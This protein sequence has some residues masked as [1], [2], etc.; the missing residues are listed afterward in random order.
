MF[1]LFSHCSFKSIGCSFLDGSQL[2]GAAV[3]P[4]CELG[5]ARCWLGA[6]GAEGTAGPGKPW[7]RGRGRGWVARVR[8]VIC[9]VSFL[10]SPF[11][12]P[13]RFSTVTTFSFIGNS[14]SWCC[15]GF[16]ERFPSS[17][18][19]GKPLPLWPGAP[20]T[21]ASDGGGARG[22]RPRPRARAPGLEAEAGVRL[23]PTREGGP[24]RR[25]GAG[26]RSLP[27]LVFRFAGAC[28]R[29]LEQGRLVLSLVIV[30]RCRFSV[31][32]CLSSS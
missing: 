26:L 9:F 32:L 4:V 25:A 5:W 17:P 30:R 22:R 18:W 6:G 21:E 23:H 29:R 7:G 3:L 24:A 13:W 2:S 20:T 1:Y 15:L 10:R 8:V 11:V 28:F 14:W 19:S 27:E 12:Q 31:H 16:L